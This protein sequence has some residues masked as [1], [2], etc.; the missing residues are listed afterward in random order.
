[1]CTQ[2]F[3]E[4]TPFYPFYPLEKSLATSEKPILWYKLNSTFAI[5]MKKQLFTENGKVLLNLQIPLYFIFMSAAGRKQHLTYLK[6]F[7]SCLIK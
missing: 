4:G 7:S 6:T 1:M 3:S 2:I 5:F